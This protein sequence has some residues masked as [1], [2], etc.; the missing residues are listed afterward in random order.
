MIQAEILHNKLFVNEN[1]VSD[2]VKFDTVRFVFP[3]SWKDYTK[4]AVFSD[5]DGV[6]VNIIL[7]K[8]NDLCINENECYIPHEVLKSHSFGLS[9]FGILGDSV[10]TT[11]KVKIPVLKSGYAEGDKPTEPTESEYQQLINLATDT[12]EIAQSVRDDADNGVFKGEKGA[13]GERGEKGDRGEKG[14]KGDTGEVTLEYA[15]N[16]FAP[17][18]KNSVSGTAVFAND[19]SDIEHNLEIKLRN[20]NLCPLESFVIESGGG[21]M[22]YDLPAGLVTVS[23]EIDE[24]LSVPN[25]EGKLD[26]NKGVLLLGGRES[27]GSECEFNLSENG[28]HYLTVEV[29]DDGNIYHLGIMVSGNV[30]I[31]NISARSDGKTEYSPHISDFSNVTVSRYGK[32]LFDKSIPYSHY[33]QIVGGYRYLKIWVGKGTTVTVSVAEKYDDSSGADYFYCRANGT[34]SGGDA[35]T[36]WLYYRG[37]PSMCQKSRTMVSEDGYIALFLTNGAY[38]FFKD[39]IQVEI[40]STCSEYEQFIEQQIANSNA[41]GEVEGITSLSTNMTVFANVDGAIIDLT[42]N[43]D[44]KRYID[45]KIAQITK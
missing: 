15:N 22:P 25:F 42:Y 35:G 27:V 3:D 1:T 11:T 23:F 19:V 21:A 13:Q 40:N 43:A 44:T 10:A 33:T 32:N 30:A 6:C 31:K 2:S 39:E 9:V 28:R 26:V 18:I 41:N 29:P 8:G 4:T 16:I 45:N 17:A 12:K 5:D 38:S 24:E 20:Q 36:H 7:E 14:E 34:Q 37:I